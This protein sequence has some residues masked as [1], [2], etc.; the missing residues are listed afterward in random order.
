MDIFLEGAV[1][2]IY[3]I[4]D[5]ERTIHFRKRPGKTY[6]SR[7]IPVQGER[8]IRIASKV[9]DS[10][11]SHQHAI[12]RGEVVLRVTQGGRQ[13]FDAKFYEYDRGIFVLTMQR[14]RH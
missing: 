7:S 9:I 2:G 13:E 4:M 1:A 8:R 14:Y 11:E 5:D 10:A 6:V 3:P 12:E